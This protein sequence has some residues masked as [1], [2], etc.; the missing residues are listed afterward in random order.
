MA[1]VTVDY[2]QL[3]STGGQLKRGREELESK[4]NQLKALVGQLVS[5][6]FVTDLASGKF[7]ESFT[8]WQTG[9]TNAVAG[10][11]GMSAFL[12]QAIARHQ[13]LD[14]QLSR[15]TGA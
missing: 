15:S 6:G 9:T 14:S 7:Q 1:N 5:S 8:Q 2:E 3:R 12:D 13:E 4:I 10:L 11:E